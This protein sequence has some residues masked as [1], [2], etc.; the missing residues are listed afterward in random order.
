MKVRLEKQFPLPATADAAWAV[1]RDVEQVGACMPGAT[2]K[3][4]VDDRH[5]KGTVTVRFGPATMSFR[6]EIEVLS[7]DPQT[8]TLRLVGKGTD[9]TGGSGA[10]MDLTAR[11]EPVDDGTSRL[12]GE[13]EVSMSG[14]AAAFGGRMMDTVADQVLKQFAGNFAERARTQVQV[15]PAAAVASSAATT[16]ALA[17]TSAGATMT[18]AAATATSAAP[19][20]TNRALP[21]EEAA[22]VA[23]APPQPA[24]SLDGFGL[25]WAVLRDWL[26]S[27]FGTR[28]A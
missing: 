28:R 7:L 20:T 16:G 13:S 11:I 8:R 1:L 18:G 17:T 26:R 19:T 6:G 25:A 10:A 14:K 4:R 12:V 21:A 3:E 9:S 27:L 23:P 15:A 5:Y 22:R 2:I 24:A